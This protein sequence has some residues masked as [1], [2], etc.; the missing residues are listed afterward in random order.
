MPPGYFFDLSF[1]KFFSLNEQETKFIK[2]HAMLGFYAWQLHGHGQFQNDAFLHGL[3]FDLAFPTLEIK[4]SF[5]GY[6]GYIGDGDRPMVYRLIFRSKFDSVFNYELGF[7][8]GF[9]DFNYTSLRLSCNS[10]LT[11]IKK[12]ITQNKRL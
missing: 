3:G 9:Q 1:G 7:Q 2:P 12:H 4:N 6:Y 8:Q 11:K 5:G 10:N